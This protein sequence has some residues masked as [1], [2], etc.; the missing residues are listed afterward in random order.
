MTGTSH[1]CVTGWLAHHITVW[2]AHHTN[3]WQDSWHTIHAYDWMSG[4]SHSFMTKWL[5][6]HTAFDWTTGTPHRF[7][8]RRLAHHA[9]FDWTTGTP[10]SFMT[11][12]LAHDTAF[13]W[14]TGTLQELF[15][16]IIGA[17]P[18]WLNVQY[19]FQFSVQTPG[20]PIIS[21]PGWLTRP[22][23]LRFRLTSTRLSECMTDVNSSDL[24]TYW[25]WL[26]P[27]LMLQLFADAE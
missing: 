15:D 3:L 7:M 14:T 17:L 9:A 12:R 8:N 24:L 27:D 6:H 16:W 4:T 5:A 25:H 23:A 1:S 26:Q 18:R 2:L 19:A 11:R 13:Y 22:A 20:M 10:H 21:L